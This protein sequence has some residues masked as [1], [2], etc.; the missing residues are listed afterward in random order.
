MEK[1]QF[2]GFERHEYNPILRP[3]TENL[4]INL[5]AECKPK[6]ILEI[7]T[8]IGYSASV[9]LRFC[10]AF[11]TTVEIDPQNA[12][13]AKQNL[14]EF[15]GRFE[16]VC[17]DAG[18]FLEQDKD[19]FDFVFLDGPKGQYKNYLPYLKRILNV[20]GVLVAD[21]ILF[22]GLVSSKEPIKHKHRS[23][24]NNLRIFLETLKADED[25]ETQIF[26]FEDGVSVSRKIK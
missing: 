19:R 2:V 9:M 16:V 13:D 7:G 14:K 12:L 4:L 17:A 15:E 6:K 3:R 22:Y 1:E 10:D 18:Q 20:G 8:F 11:L 26:D 5:L 24:V 25:F 21:D 23:I